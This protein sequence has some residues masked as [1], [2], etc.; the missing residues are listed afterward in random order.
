MSFLTLTFLEIVLGVDNIIFISI[1]SARL[2]EEDKKKA[3]NLG[4]LAAMV[5]RI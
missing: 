5:L 4:L 2:A 3:T 1:T